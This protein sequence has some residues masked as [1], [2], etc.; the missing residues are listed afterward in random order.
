V[1]SDALFVIRVL[2]YAHSVTRERTN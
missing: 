1:G 2:E